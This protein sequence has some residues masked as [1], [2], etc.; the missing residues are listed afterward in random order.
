M[1]NTERHWECLSQGNED[2]ASA[3]KDKADGQ[4]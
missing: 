4:S 2:S 3:Y 1:K